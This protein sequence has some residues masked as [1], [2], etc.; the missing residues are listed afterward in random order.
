MN[1]YDDEY[2]NTRFGLNSVSGIIHTALKDK[3]MKKTFLEAKAIA[4]Y[5]EVVGKQIADASIP[6]KIQDGVLF[7][8]CKSSS[9]S[10]ELTLLKNEI[11][12]K[13]NSYVGEKI[14]KDIKFT[15]R[16]YKQLLANRKYGISDEDRSKITDIILNDDEMEKIRKKAEKIEFDDLREKIIKTL[17]T[18]K[19]REKQQ[20]NN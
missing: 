20:Q 5:Q 7:V 8:C 11:I 19:K 10:N 13:M 2:I 4:G 1:F 3:G 12:K 6:E 9:W 18:A 16:G 15:S 14:I 17:I